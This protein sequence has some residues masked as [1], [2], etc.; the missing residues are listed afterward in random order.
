MTSPTWWIFDVILGLITFIESLRGE[1][2]YSYC[3][4]GVCAK[5]MI[6]KIMMIILFLMMSVALQHSHLAHCC[7]HLTQA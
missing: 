4:W 3:G 7:S 1:L 6:M 2:W 5:D